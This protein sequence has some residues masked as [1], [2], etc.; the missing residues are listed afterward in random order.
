M[1]LLVGDQEAL[2]LDTG[3]SAE[4]PLRETIDELIGDLPLIVSHSHAHGDH[5]AGDGQFSLRPNTRVVGH[6]AEEVASFF[7]F[8]AWPTETATLDL[9]GRELSIIPIPGH[10]ASS[11]AIYDVKTGLLLTG[12]TFYPGRLYVRDAAAYRASIDRLVQLASTRDVS[13]VLGTHIE[14]TR[15]PGVDYPGGATEHPAERELQLSTDH[16][17]ELH[18]TLTAMGEQLERRV[19]DHFVLF[20]LE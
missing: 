9:G 18:Q 3:A 12:D 8:E 5:V 1:Y 13:W 11:I 17:R 14:M 15:E 19:H 7:G 16:L 6:S 2:L 20:P 10:Q 4:I